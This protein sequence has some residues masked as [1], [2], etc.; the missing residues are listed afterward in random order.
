MNNI[1]NLYPHNIEIYDKVKHAYLSGEDIVG[2]LQATGTG[3]TYLGLQLALDNK[4]KKI[5]YVTPYK[6]II[7]HIKEIIDSNP[8]LDFEKDFSHVKFINYNTLN[9]LS[10]EELQDLD[11]DMLILDEFHHIGAPVWGSK[12]EKI[13]DSH[14]NLKVFG[15]SAYSV[16]DRGTS[17]ERDM[18]LPGGNEI[19]SDKIVSNYDLV[20]AMLDGV[21]PFPIYKSA[22]IRLLQLE[23]MLEDKVKIKY[24]K[25]PNLT[26]YLRI[27]TDLKKQIAHGLDTKELLFN[28]LKSDGK[29]I[30]FCPVTQIK[31]N[32]DIKTIV[33]EF[34]DFLISRGY[35]ED[36]FEFYI[37]TSE[38][39]VGGRINRLAFYNDISLDGKNVSSKLR[40]MFAINQYNEG[41]H[42]PNVN[43][44]ILGRFTKSDIVF[45]E[46]I[47]RAL[48]V[49]GDTIKKIEEYSKLSIEEIK[50]KCRELDITYDDKMTKS[51]L[52][53][54][55]VAP[56]I[57]DLV[58]NIAF[59]K[60]LMNQVK[61]R[62]MERVNS[63][64]KVKRTIKFTD[65]SYELDVVGISLLEELMKIKYEFEPKIWEEC[66]EL[67][68]NYFKTYGN[69]DISRSFKTD[70]GILYSEYGYALGNWVA[71]MR[72]KYNEGTLEQDK[73]DK[74]NLIKFKFRLRKT[75]NESYEL[76]KEYYE[77]Y[78]NLRVPYNYITLDGFNLS[79]WIFNI[80]SLY[81]K[82]KLDSA[83]I[84]ML[85]KIGMIWN[86][87]RSWNES[88]DIAVKYFNIYG[89]LDLE[90]DYIVDDFSL[91]DWLNYQR[92]LKLDSKLS[93]Q[94][95]ELL[96]K[97]NFNWSLE[98]DVVL[99]KLDWYGMYELAKKYF[100][101]YK[102]LK[103]KRGFRTF[104]GITHDD[105]GYRLGA[106]IS[107]QR[108]FKKNN[109]LT[110][111]QIKALDGINMIWNENIV[112]KTW[113]ESYEIAKKFYMTFGHLSVG[114]G[115]KTIDG[116]SY[117][118]D[119]YDLGSFIYL[120]RKKYDRNLLSD[121]QISKLDAIGM[122]WNIN[123]NYARIKQIFKDYGI[124]SRK[125]APLV[126]H[127]SLKEFGCKVNYL[128]ANGLKIV[129]N[130]TLHEI[131]NMSEANM[132]VKYNISRKE[133]LD[134]YGGKELVI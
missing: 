61:V 20:D 94:K 8:Y 120:Q 124:N 97:L 70:D 44:V 86:P 96:D 58:G 108:N 114:T 125:Y 7:E 26:K 113:D 82:G 78:G 74:L 132:I 45:Y 80:R 101:E 40:I 32:N 69:S 24:D 36:D 100:L 130:K 31:G 21:L 12:I 14:N 118:E 15:M 17:L 6:S 48:S 46:Q 19:F 10:D 88:Y 77:T 66:Y 99:E 52:I 59:M 63:G 5:V 43:G 121:E 11:L 76:A 56:T 13:I 22:Y 37:T 75:F 133:L 64:K 95:Q 9:T 85:N 83:K 38:D 55:L 84:D 127:L 107:R 62:A 42:A 60:D 103:V 106:W 122:I 131:F 49:R 68:V 105:N 71:E 16:R 2:I 134:N 57:L 47:G 29:Y 25:N 27:L 115:F 51:D 35:K 33:K 50:V 3:K 1:L 111:E 72:R 23:E 30:Y 87:I 129:D 102:N 4:N 65:N 119:G 53:E 128:V 123:K 28:N 41:V 39:T 67:A 81:K 54:R 34:S 98:Q 79:M 90:E 117:I 109:K 104:D 126:K 93:K 89:N 18:A 91:L 116:C 110:S 73:I 112:Y 92:K